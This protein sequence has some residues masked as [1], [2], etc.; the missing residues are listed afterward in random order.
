MDKTYRF[1]SANMGTVSVSVVG[2]WRDGLKD[3][4]VEVGD[5]CTQLTRSTA[6]APRA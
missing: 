2:E 1:E 3:L 5:S 4:Q 6:A